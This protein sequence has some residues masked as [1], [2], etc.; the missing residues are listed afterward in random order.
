MS[1]VIKI[2]K[3]LDIPL[4]GKSEKVFG[5]AQLPGLFAVKPTDFHGIVPK[6]VVKEGDAVKIGSVL[7]YDK[8]HPEV[9]F[10]SPVSG[11]LKSVNRG[12]RRRILEV[13]VENDG[14]DDFIDFG[15][16]DPSKSER[17]SIVEK[18]LE[19]G[20]WPYL[21]QRPY[22]VIANPA[23]TPKAIF[24][25]GFDSAPLAPDMDFVLTGQEDELTT[26]FEVLKKLA[27]EVHVGISS[28]SASK[29]FT[30]LKGVQIHSFDG[31][32][33]AGN[34]GVQIHHT[35]PINKGEKVWVIQPQA[36][37]SIG[38]LFLKGKHDFS[39]VIALT[40]SEVV[41]PSYYRYRMGASVSGLI[42]DNLIND[43][44]LRII[45]GNVLTGDHIE[46]DGYIGFNH[47]QVTVIPEG[48]KHEFLGWILPGLEKFSTS[49]TFFS[50]LRP[51]KEYRIDANT[52][53]GERAIVIS[54]QYDSVLPMD[55]LA[56]FLI[57]AIM[58]EDIDKMEQLGI[59]EVVEE[60]LALSE[61]VDTS[62]IEIQSI[63]R[64][65]IDLMIKELG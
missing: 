41:K 19:S 65:G 3:G 6:M 16:A 47:S 33:P 60:D 44:K 54:G 58:I 14:Q 64:K 31:P 53:G 20:A 48:D 9:K 50:W 32:H 21:R 57:K 2:K 30:N 1:E 8:Y 29:V 11:R 17:A 37:V 26:G 43:E 7:F 51:N 15:A 35:I 25:S 45:S 59:Y 34:V 23:D 46:E 62:K 40:G 5:Q 4:K 52:K 36:I 49:R 12:E 10:V 56:E 38:R 22:D 61:F 13:I 39:R 63:L 24:V 28:S 27:P 55:I 42:K 18:L